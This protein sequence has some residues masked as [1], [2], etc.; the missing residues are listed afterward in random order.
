MLL[1]DRIR[2][3]VHPF[4]NDLNA[5]GRTTDGRI[6]M[7]INKLKSFEENLQNHSSIEKDVNI[8]I[9]Y[10]LIEVNKPIESM[11]NKEASISIYVGEAISLSHKRALMPFTIIISLNSALFRIR[12]EIILIGSSESI[13]RIIKFDDENSPSVYFHIYKETIRILNCLSTLLLNC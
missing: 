9:N 3:L 13:K 7:E 8:S 2:H 12:G 5:E 10:R 11:L 4:I 6:K 1:P